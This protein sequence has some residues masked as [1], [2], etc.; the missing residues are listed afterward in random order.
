MA[1]NKKKMPRFGS[2]EELADFFDGNDMSEFAEDM[3]EAEFDVN[4][5]SRSFYVEVE[6]DLAE[7]IN[8][9]SKREHVSSGAI[10]NTW[11]REKLSNRPARS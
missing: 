10:V 4:L 11:L 8:E 7:Q 5:K 9:I 3:A 1:E 2:V 6:T